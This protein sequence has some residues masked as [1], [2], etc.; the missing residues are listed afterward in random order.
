MVTEHNQGLPPF[1]LLFFLFMYQSENK[2]TE[3]RKSKLL[4]KHLLLLA[5]PGQT[6]SFS[7]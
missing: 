7:F 5:G 4:L 3:T 6:E 1:L 2:E